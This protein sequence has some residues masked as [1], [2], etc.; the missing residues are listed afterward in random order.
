LADIDGNLKIDVKDVSIVSKAYGS[1]DEGFGTP[2]ASPNFSARADVNADG[3]IDIKDV[4]RVSKDFGKIF[5]P[6]DP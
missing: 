2:V 4:S 3:K 1:V 5:T 6:E